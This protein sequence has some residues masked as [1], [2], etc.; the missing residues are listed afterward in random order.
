METALQKLVKI[1]ELER[2]GG[3]RNRAVIGGVER[4]IPVWIEE[5]RAQAGTETEKALVE[6][7]GDLLVDYGRLPGPSARGKLVDAIRERLDR[8]IAASLPS[9]P[10]PAA[11]DESAALLAEEAVEEPAPARQEAPERA[12]EEPELS[13]IREGDEAQETIYPPPPTRPSPAEEPAP[14]QVTEAEDQPAAE[15][16]EAGSAVVPSPDQPA[17]QPAPSQ[18]P[19]KPAP[20]TSRPGAVI[21][22]GL[23]ASV[24]TLRGVGPRMADRLEK[25][26]VRTI[27]DMLH[28]FPRRYVDYSALKP[29]NRLTYGETVTIIGT[30]QETR[31]QDHRRGRKLIHSIIGDGTATI[32]CTWFNQ[33]WLANRLRAGATVMIS[34]KVDQYLG[35][36]VFQSPEWEPV[37]REQLHTGRIVPI[38]PLTAGLTAKVL[39][40]QM[41]RVVDYWARRT[42]DPLPEEIRRRQGLIDL[43]TALLQIHFPDN[44]DRLAAARRRLVFDEL[45]VLQLGMLRLRSQWQSQ[46]GVPLVVEDEWLDDFVGRLAFQLTSAQQRALAD[47]R[48]DM[49]SSVPMNRLLQGDVG[50]GK[51]VVAAAAMTMAVQSEAQA[52]LMA[53]TEILAEQHASGISQLLAGEP[54]GVCV[55]L[56]TGSL[57]AAEKGAVYD[58]LA[59]GTVDVVVGTHALIQSGVE[60]K[61]LGLAIVDEQHRF[62][63]EQRAALRQKGYNPHVLV[64]TATPIPRTLALSLYGDLDISVIDEMPPGRQ[65]VATRWLQPAARERAYGFVRAQVEEGRQAFIICPLIEASDKSEAKAATDEYRRLQKSVFPDLKLGLLHGRMKSDE[66]EAVMAGFYRGETQVLVSTSV[67][68]VGIDVPNASVMLVEGANRFGLAQLHQFRGRVGRGEHKSYCLLLA[69]STTPEAEER[70]SALEAT[71][72]GFVLAEKDLELRGPG[73]FFGTRQSGLPDL[74]L[75]S[76]S[77]VVTLE[78]ARKE[79]QALFEQDISLED[80]DHRLLARKVDQFWS[81]LGDVS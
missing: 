40:N 38:Y 45:F 23:D 72:D 64:M 28:L 56:L 8:A 29:I 2:Q 34:G 36:L 69:D 3:Y 68:E 24:Q 20:R 4:Y 32:R 57:S 44:G 30:V 5:A 35:R 51:T 21:P 81:G 63:V 19:P 26:G 9:Q 6:Q 13:A 22:S 49:A 17:P 27:Q 78:E 73:E 39:R 71:N 1:L 50:S 46:P 80:P 37:E 65:P 53:P 11:E 59:D 60:F 18:A 76:I 48:G 77:D 58:G 75:A 52:A 67:V 55:R 47:V 15:Q 7:I 74:R 16:L 61:R 25:L 41:K 54:D 66:K 62:G 14:A 79:A 70:L 43:E 12:E 10:A 33:P 31:V 42:P